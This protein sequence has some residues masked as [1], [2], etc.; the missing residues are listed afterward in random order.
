[1]QAEPETEID[2]ANREKAMVLG[3]RLFRWLFY[4]ALAFTC[5]A[6]AVLYG[7]TRGGGKDAQA[8]TA[9]GPCAGAQA[10][11]AAI[12]PLVRGEVA[13]LILAKTPRP[14][15]DISFNAPDG[16]RVSLET[17]RGRTILLNLWATWCIPCRQEM[18]ALD[19]LQGAQGDETF[20]VVTVNIDTARLEKPRQMLF[21]IGVRNLDFYADPAAEIFQTLRSFSKV[22]G[23]PAT[24]LIDK[25]GCEIGL[26]AGPA[27]WDSSDAQA[28]V[29]AAKG[30]L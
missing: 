30:A 17:F 12:S 4:S 14:L 21:D 2:P 26:M 3:I 16:K 15:P 13:A 23:L 5:L 6:A 8:A 11:V 28:L 7:I 19:R 27:E 25:Q 22:Q 18:P 1:M 29:K 9:T 24:L 20:K 10:V